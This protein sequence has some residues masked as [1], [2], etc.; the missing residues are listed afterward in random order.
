VPGEGRV[1][2]SPTILGEKINV[3]KTEEAG[4]KLHRPFFLP[5]RAYLLDLEGSDNILSKQNYERRLE[6]A[7]V[8]R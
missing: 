4:G 8:L 3:I 7:G 5:G 2:G 6:H 1:E